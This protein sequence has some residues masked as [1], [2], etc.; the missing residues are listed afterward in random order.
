MQL[1]GLTEIDEIKSSRS[2][3]ELDMTC[4]GSKWQG[5]LLDF[6]KKVNGGLALS[7][8]AKILRS[9]DTSVQS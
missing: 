5:C 8:R 4:K 6:N 7:L 2:N 9:Q 1:D 3:D